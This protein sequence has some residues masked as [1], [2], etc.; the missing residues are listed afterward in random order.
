MDSKK[1]NLYYNRFLPISLF[2][3]FCRQGVPGPGQYEIYR[4][5]DPTSDQ[6]TE[7]A[8][9]LTQARVRSISFKHSRHCMM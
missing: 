9:F 5:F 2:L 1:A 4:S 8:P 7:V 6:I 3:L